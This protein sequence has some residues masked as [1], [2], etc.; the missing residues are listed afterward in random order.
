MWGQRQGSKNRKSKILS[1][2]RKILTWMS[3]CK[4][5]HSEVGWSKFGIFLPKMFRPSL[6]NNCSKALT[7]YH[8]R[9]SRAQN[10]LLFP[11]Q[12]HKSRLN[13][14]SRIFFL[15]LTYQ[16]IDQWSNLLLW[17][18]Q[19]KSNEFCTRLLRTW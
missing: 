4:I 9:N 16:T 11:C 10:S 18:W 1:T 5:C 6:K 12:C 15:L 3:N 19:G 2:W 17:H 13:H 8:V 7:N 14:W